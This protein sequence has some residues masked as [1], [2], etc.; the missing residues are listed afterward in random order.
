MHYLFTNIIISLTNWNFSYINL[1]RWV[2]V[3]KFILNIDITSWRGKMHTTTRRKIAH[4]H[5][6][7]FITGKKHSDKQTLKAKC[8]ALLTEVSANRKEVN[9]WWQLRRRQQR[10]LQQRRPQKKRRNKF[11]STRARFFWAGEEILQPSFCGLLY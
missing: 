11:P 6:K 5:L 8:H 10:K 7:I 3:K 4:T 1:Y 9:I 2:N